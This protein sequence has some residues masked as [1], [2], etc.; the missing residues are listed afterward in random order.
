MKDNQ[1]N[2]LN[3]LKKRNNIDMLKNKNNIQSILKKNYDKISA[4]IC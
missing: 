1:M 4:K 3:I 2:K